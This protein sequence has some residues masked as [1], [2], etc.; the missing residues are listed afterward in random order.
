MIAMSEEAKVIAFV[1]FCI[2][3]YKAA[4]NLSG[5]GVS[6]L[7]TRF[8]VDRYLYEEYEVLHTMGIDAVLA[9]IDRFLEVRGGVAHGEINRTFEVCSIGGGDMGE[10][11]QSNVHLL[12]PWKIAG[13]AELWARDAN[14]APLEAME[15]FYQTS[16]YKRLADES[17]KLWH[18]SAEQLYALFGA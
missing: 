5:E 6:S 10:I 16:F 7:F 14:I 18:Y 2:E 3:S 15:R 4:K 12:L 8:G 17:T 9:D 13:I 11:N 1:A